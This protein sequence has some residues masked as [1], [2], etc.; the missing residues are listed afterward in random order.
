MEVDLEL[1]AKD[2]FKE[3]LWDGNVEQ[4]AIWLDGDW[5]VT[6]TVHFDERNKAC[7]PVLVLNLRDVFAK[8][9]FSFDTIEELINKIENILNGHEPIDV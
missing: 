7:E 6:S 9:D 2:L 1:Q 8:I 5:S 3:V 4:I